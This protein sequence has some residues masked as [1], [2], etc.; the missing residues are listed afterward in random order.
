MKEWNTQMKK[1]TISLELISSMDEELIGKL[2]DTIIKCADI[3]LPEVICNIGLTICDNKYI[4]ELNKEYRDKDS[5]TDVLSFPML[6]AECAGE[7]IYSDMDKD[8]ETG[9]LMLGDIVISYERAKEQ[10]EEYGH[11][12]EREV[13][14][15]AVHSMLHLVG[16]D[17]MVESD[18]VMMRE[19]EESILIKLN[20]NR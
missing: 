11:S 7:I 16:Y 4:K 2:E 20:I 19:K 5:A 10:A 13:C 17:H 12:V 3:L 1:T 9:E 6:D 15:L 18:K 14:Y 8:P